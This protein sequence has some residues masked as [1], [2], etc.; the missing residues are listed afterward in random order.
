M[1]RP[2]VRRDNDIPDGSPEPPIAI[3]HTRTTYRVPA[4]ELWN[5][6]NPRKGLD[7]SILTPENQYPPTTVCSFLAKT[8]LPQIDE[9]KENQEL[10]RPENP[11][12]GEIVEAENTWKEVSTNPRRPRNHIPSLEARQKEEKMLR[13]KEGEE[14]KKFEAELKKLEQTLDKIADYTGSSGGME[15]VYEG[16]AACGLLQIIHDLGAAKLK[17]ENIDLEEYRAKILTAVVS[18]E[19]QIL[20]HF[21]GPKHEDST[22]TVSKD[23]ENISNTQE[24][25]DDIKMETHLA[26][27]NPPPSN[28]PSS[29]VN[30]YTDVEVPPY[31]PASPA[32]DEQYYAPATPTSLERG[33]SPFVP[34]SPTIKEELSEVRERVFRVE[35]RVEEIGDELKRKLREIEDQEMRDVC[36]YAEWK[37]AKAELREAE[38]KAWSDRK[39][40]S[41]RKAP[42][43]EAGHRYPMRNSLATD[44][45]LAEIQEDIAKLTERVRRLEECQEDVRQEIAEINGGYTDVLA[46]GSRIE[47]IADLTGANRKALDDA[48][49]ILLA[50]IATLRRN[51]GPVH[52]TRLRQHEFEINVLSSKINQFYSF[53][54]GILHPNST[55][56]SPQPTTTPLAN[57]TNVL[58]NKWIAAC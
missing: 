32:N 26:D 4:D 42:K 5:P 46:L 50:D 16:L 45:R 13:L 58:E 37:W 47:V 48:I 7:Y 14:V 28:P 51:L 55:T 2:Q 8:T 44:K 11:E 53:A 18:H 23:Q 57:I 56:T 49:K 43:H 34:R 30:W 36:E 19:E 31:A 17:G 33:T 20:A 6:E 39:K 21:G 12:P 9:G 22:C 27:D 35:D 54:A 40:T 41:R 15:D 24:T 10:E 52:E 1:N 38:N 29:P 3:R 25:D